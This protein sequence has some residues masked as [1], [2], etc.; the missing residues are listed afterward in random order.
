MFTNS[1]WSLVLH[2]TVG[3]VVAVLVVIQIGHG[4][5]I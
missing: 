5:Q 2:A 3:A 4:E 1:S